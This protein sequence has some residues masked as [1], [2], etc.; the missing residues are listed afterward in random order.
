M[1]LDKGL[2]LMPNATSKKVNK[3]SELCETIMGVI[4]NN[5][6]KSEDFFTFSLFDKLHNYF[7][8]VTKEHLVPIHH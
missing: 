8:G 5:V 6:T 4:R 7:Q 3:V 2:Q 1:L